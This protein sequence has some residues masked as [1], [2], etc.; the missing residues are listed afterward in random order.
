[1]ANQNDQLFNLIRSVQRRLKTL[2]TLRGLALCLAASAALL[3]LTGLAAWRWRHSGGAL[4]SLRLLALFGVLAAIWFFVVRPLRKRISDAQVARLV[5]ERHRGMEERLV[6]AV[7]VSHESASV[8]ASAVAERLLS[9]ARQRAAT[10]ELNEIV[11]KQRLWKL[12]GAAA[13]CVVAFIGALMFGPKPL[14]DGVGAL[15]S[16]P[17]VTATDTSVMQIK[18]K[19]GT[20]RVPKGSDQQ[21]TATLGNFNA[22][23]VTFFFRKVG[24][25]EQ[26]WIG[27]PMEPAKNK[28][29]FQHFIFNIQEPVEYFVEANGV[30]SEVYKLDVADLPYVKRID[31]TLDFP[32]YTGL[33]SKTQEDSGNIAALKGTVVTIKAILTGGQ[34]VKAK[35][36]FIVLKD[37]KKIEM[38]P[39]EQRLESG[40]V[41]SFFTSALT[42]T[43][44]TSYHIELHSVDGDVYN[45]SNE[46]DISLLED[47]PPT[48]SFDKP[49]RDTRATNIEEVFTQAKAEDDYGVTSLDLY[50][51][52]NGGEEKKLDLQK[53]KGAAKTL[54]GAH[55]FFLE[56][57][58]LKPGDF[59]SYY[60][61]ARDAHQE[62][63]S[64]IYFIE[65]KPFEKEFRQAQQ[66]GGS[67]AGGEQ[68]QNALTKRQKEIIAATFRVNKEQ[69]NYA[70]DEKT[71]NYNAV[72]LSQEKLRDDARA[73]IERI[74]RRMGGQLDQQN[75][76]AKLVEYLEQ[77][78][79]E[80]EAAIPELRGQKADKALPPEQRALQQLLR[81]DAIFREI[82]VAMGQ[83]S[84]GGGQSQNAEEL[85]DLFELELDKMKNQYETLQREQQQQGQQ[86]DDETKR[87]L[88]EL[89]RRQQRELEQQQRRQ[90]AARNQ[91]GGGG[92]SSRQ[93]Q[94][95][96]DETRKAARELERLS[97]ERRDQRLQELS[98]QL[99]QAADQMQQAQ[100]AAQNNNQQESISQQLRALEKLEEARRRMDQLQRSRGGQSASDLRQRAADAAARQREIQ[101]DVDELARKSQNGQNNDQATQDKKQQLSER[102]EALAGDVNNLEKD[103]DQT[104][105][106]IGQDQQKAADQMREA[107]STLRRNRV[108]E[109]IRRN[110]QNIQDGQFGAAREGERTIQENLDQLAEQLRQAEQQAKNAKGAGS[111]TEEALDRTRQLVDS[112]ESIRRRMAENQRGQQQQNSQQSQQ[113][114]PSAQQQGQQQN[115][116]QGQQ[117]AQQGRQEQ[118]QGQQNGRQ[119]GQQNQ[120]NARQQGQQQ[121]NGQQ[122]GQQQGQSQ[123]QEGQQGQQ[124]GQQQGQQSAQGGQQSQNSS[125]SNQNPN[126]PMGGGPPRSGDRVA[127]S[128]RQLKAELAE[129]LSEAEELRRQIGRERGDLARDLDQA[130]SQLR[131]MAEQINRNDI[132]DDLHTAARLKTEVIDPLRQIEVELS[133]R[134][135]AKL[136]KNNLRL[137]DEGAAPERYRKQV[138]EYYKRLSSGSNQPK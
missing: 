126:R 119:K 98:R 89:A 60:A 93:Q 8:S 130:I 32:A 71:E 24:G 48:V 95:L 22:D 43:Q 64:D 54:T 16:P 53:L 45:G 129:R 38:K 113:G 102:K 51:S 67:G 26:Q 116:Q 70:A 97:R 81:A 29:D 69:A 134:L 91:S 107:A 109:R 110:N 49:G 19:P 13:A 52:V 122:P 88:E 59:I 101:K 105:R 35:T 137:A 112:L 28:T 123:G 31:A 80:M 96:I 85:A 7:E 65:V 136:G 72:A 55:T 10:V 124:P 47:A 75:D 114:Q 36:A 79:K 23:L 61:K 12:A 50:F 127:D 39:S 25:G 42:V 40:Q 83:Q 133:R 68:N 56:E 104:A 63:T 115:Q 92:G 1:M 108:A 74:K 11:P 132:R 27:Q 125:P 117:S 20:A 84:G 46:F 4:I 103:L 78:H 100:S 58:D 82:Q 128:N 3:M 99:N 9:D 33:P 21:I 37:G 111:E 2:A 106:G 17:T 138:E 14:S 66:Q 30:K 44:E 135:Q 5:E 73:L 18:V 86:Q 76:F 15:L 41:E 57:Y 121:Q 34:T 87:K 90:Q 131:Q 6:S 77:A 62:A 120:Q 118:Q 94:E